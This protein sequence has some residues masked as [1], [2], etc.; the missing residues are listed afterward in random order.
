VLLSRG[1]AQAAL[2]AFDNGLRRWPNNAGRRFQA[3]LAARD[4]GDYDRAISELR[5]SLRADPTATDAA[6]M[7]ASLEL[8]R[9]N[10][11]EATEYAR[12]FVRNRGGSRPEGHLL[13]VRALVA[14]ELFD[15]AR[16]AAD[17]MERAGLERDTVLARSIIASAA[18]GPASAVATI[19]E[20]RLDLALAENETVLRALSE[21]LVAAGRS[22]EAIASVEPAIARNPESASLHELRGTLLLRAGRQADAST[23][24]EKVLAL[25]P[26]NARA[27]AG[28]AQVAFE[29]GD[30]AR[31]LALY[32]EAARANPQDQSAA[33]AAAQLALASGDRVGAQQRL[34][35]IVRRDA[36]HA[37]ARNDLAWILAQANE[38][39]DRALSLA[40]LAH[41]IDPS[42]DIADTLGFVHLQRGENDKAAA[43]FEEAV[44]QRPESQS[45]RYH[46]GLALARQGEHERALASL[47]AALAAG[48]FPEAEAARSE[49]A[50]LE[51]Q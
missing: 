9:G 25:D 13:L 47:R 17:A 23:A 43:L 16:R 51:S 38:D 22:D 35:E 4:V 15:A 29:R 49:M 40:Q 14:Q 44:Q 32:D 11:K 30:A 50:R 46:L 39:L 7:L 2:A 33:Y 31:A 42:P 10:P 20:G 26:N 18:S 34:E 28:L 27:K 3:G 37:G 45:M 1:E 41:R 48:P 8:A 5:E 12:G 36:G 19:R 6:L 24:L 21:A